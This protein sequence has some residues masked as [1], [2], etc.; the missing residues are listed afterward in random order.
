MAKMSRK[1]RHKY[2]TQTYRRNRNIKK[3]ENLAINILA[4]AIIFLFIIFIR[5]IF[6]N[7]Y[8]DVKISLDDVKSFRIPHRNINELKHFSETQNL[9]FEEVLSLYSI[10]NDFFPS[11]V[12]SSDPRSIDQN[13][14]ANFN[15]IRKSYRTKDIEPYKRLFEN[16]F[17]DIKYFP[18]PKGYAGDEDIRYMYGDSW[19]AVRNYKGERTHEGTDIIDR[20]NIAGH[21]PIVSMTDGVLTNIGWNELGGFRIGITSESGTYY[22]YAHFDSFANG[23]S[24]GSAIQAGQLLGYMGNTGYDKKEGTKGKFPVHLHVGIMPDVSLGKGELWVNPYPYLR[25]IEDSK[26]EY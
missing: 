5:S 2:S 7:E 15:E 14:I 9:D 10:E 22:Y 11:K 3:I 16:I 18:I 23:L 1:L 20:E 13:F 12:L 25:Y 8:K 17:N 21:I 24:N 6:F 19:G 4:V 26:V